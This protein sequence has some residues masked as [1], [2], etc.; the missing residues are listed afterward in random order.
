MSKAS[1]LLFPLSKTS[2]DVLAG[3][4]QFP[5]VGG[6]FLGDRAE[7]D[8]VGH[9]AGVDPMQQRDVEVGAD[10]QAEADLAEIATLLLIVAA[11]RQLGRCAG[12]DVSE[13]VGAVVDQGAQV[14]L[15]ALDQPPTDLLLAGGDVIGGDQI[16]VVP[17]VLGREPSRV[18]RQQAAQGR[19]AKPVGELQLAWWGRRRD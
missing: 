10:Q 12:V 1:S 18:G 7:L 8:T 6:Q 17:E 13:E 15:Q 11:L 2:R 19:L 9:V 3:L 4:G 16:H 14:E 5:V